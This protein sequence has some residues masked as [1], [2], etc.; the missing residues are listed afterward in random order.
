KMVWD[1]EIHN[2]IPNELIAWRT[3]KGA[4]V[5]H[6]G[7]VTFKDAP[8]ERGAEIRVLLQYNPPAGLVGAYFAKLFGEEPSQQIEDDLIRL[9]Q[10]LETGEI[11][12]TEGQPQGPPKYVLRFREKER[13][14]SRQ[15]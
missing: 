11:A 1:A 8:G 9:K 5:D 10:Y 2:E 12:T 3:L 15:P 14:R 4:N 13:L 6:A 7:S